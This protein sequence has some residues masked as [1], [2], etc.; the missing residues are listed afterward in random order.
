MQGQVRAYQRSKLQCGAAAFV[1]L[2]A[3]P[4]N[5]KAG[6]GKA[7]QSRTL[8]ACTHFVAVSWPSLQC[9]YTPAM[10]AAAAQDEG[11][12]RPQ[13]LSDY[14]SEDEDEDFVPGAARRRS[15]GHAH[16]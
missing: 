14:G 2:S 1:A 4:A 11:A 3:R 6:W 8:C 9:R 10:S 15:R 13:D 7:N 5:Q 12:P 16:G